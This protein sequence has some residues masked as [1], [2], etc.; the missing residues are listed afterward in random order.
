MWPWVEVYLEVDCSKVEVDMMV[1]CSKVEVV[2]WLWDVGM[3]VVMVDWQSLPVW[4]VLV[5]VVDVVEIVPA[6]VGEVSRVVLTWQSF[7]LCYCQPVQAHKVEEVEVVY[8]H[9]QPRPVQAS[10]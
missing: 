3:V 1:E 9:G 2:L 10:P 7:H 5:G 4:M 6:R 8:Y